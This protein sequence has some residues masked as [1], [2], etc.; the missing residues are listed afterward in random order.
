MSRIH[1]EYKVTSMR[2]KDS[3][4]LAELCWCWGK[5]LL[6]NAHIFTYSKII[7]IDVGTEEIIFIR[8][9]QDHSAVCVWKWTAW[10]CHEKETQIGCYLK[11]YKSKGGSETICLQ[12]LSTDVLYFTAQFYYEVGLCLFVC[13]SSVWVKLS[14][15]TE[16]DTHELNSWWQCGIIKERQHEKSSF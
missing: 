7:S 4:V 1:W 13:S 11:R 8:W 2:S 9:L 10:D 3:V 5:I 12:N 14:W 6:R 16:T 15:C